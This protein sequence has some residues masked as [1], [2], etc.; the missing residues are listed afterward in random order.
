MPSQKCPLRVSCPPFFIVYWRTCVVDLRSPLLF[1]LR[2]IPAADISIAASKQNMRLS[3]RSC[4]VL[5]RTKD[6]LWLEEGNDPGSDR[7]VK[8]QEFGRAAKLLQL[9][10]FDFSCWE[11]VGFIVVI[12]YRKVDVWN[13]SDGRQEDRIYSKEKFENSDLWEKK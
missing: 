2:P 3:I 10:L 12:T 1:L 11:V 6:L 9:A 4:W 8:Q 7:V 13:E 5:P